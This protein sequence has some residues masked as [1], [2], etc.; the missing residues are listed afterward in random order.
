[1]GIRIHKSL[2]YGLHLNKYPNLDLSVLDDYEYLSAPDVFK[3]FAGSVL[4]DSLIHDAISKNII[5]EVL[6]NGKEM[7]IGRFI[8]YSNEGGDPY[9]INF[10]VD[11]KQKRYH[12]D[13]D[14]TEEM[15]LGNPD[16]TP[17]IIS[18]NIGIHPFSGS[19][20]KYN[21]I[22][23]KFETYWIPL[24]KESYKYENSIPTPPMMFYY[25][26]KTLKLTDDEDKLAEM[27]LS[28]RASVYTYWQ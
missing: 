25:L 28:L 16:L 1:M 23:K 8:D 22:N 14:Y 3:E 21:S 11:E 17:K 15:I 13:I 20:I 24:Y 26:L 27:Y 7:S 2:G 6:D 9:F 4:N 5:K 18:D 12:D 10:I 19:L